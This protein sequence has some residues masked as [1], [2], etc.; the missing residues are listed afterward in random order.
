LFTFINGSWGSPTN[1]STTNSYYTTPALAGDY[2]Y[3]FRVRALNSSGTASPWSDNRYFSY[4][5]SGNSTNLGTPTIMWPLNNTV[6]TNYPRKAY[7][8]WSEVGSASKYEI[9]LACEFC[10]NSKAKWTNPSTYTTSNLYYT[11]PALAGDYKFRFKVRAINSKNIA[12]SWSEYRYFEYDTSGG[13][14]KKT[15]PPAEYEDDV[16]TNYDD[17]ENPFSDTDLS[18]LEGIAAAELYR[19]GIIGGY[20]DGEFKGYRTVNRAEIAKFLLLAKYG[21]VSSVKNN[22]KFSDVKEGEWYVKYVVTAYNKG[23]I[24]GYSDGT[25][26]PG[27]PVSIAEALKMIA[28]TFNLKLNLSYDFKDVDSKDWFAKYAGIVEK[29]DLL[30]KK[31][32]YLNPGSKMTRNEVAVA[33]YQYLKNK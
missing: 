20:E 27:N 31:D 2:Y 19:R 11:T 9:Q 6:L 12:G 15:L 17:Y 13:T 21:E 8:E 24:N 23:I 10:S 25:F 30:P 16:I 33:I 1:H 3:Y 14:N 26:K 28:L 18:T 4:D 5:T 29:Y 7:L 32:K 22:G